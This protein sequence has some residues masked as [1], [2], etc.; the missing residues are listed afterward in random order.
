MHKTIVLLSVHGLDTLFASVRNCSWSIVPYVCCIITLGCFVWPPSSLLQHLLSWLVLISDTLLNMSI[1]RLSW[2]YW[3]IC[4][5]TS[6]HVIVDDLSSHVSSVVVCLPLSVSIHSWTSVWFMQQSTCQVLLFHKSHWFSQFSPTRNG[7]HFVVCHDYILSVEHPCCLCPSIKLRRGEIRI[8]DR[9]VR[10]GVCCWQHYCW[11]ERN[12][13]LLF[14]VPR[15][16]A[17]NC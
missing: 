2:I 8:I 7:S 1:F 16:W 15:L 10:R 3:S 14:F 4:S 9:P 12:V 5:L 6:A 13:P 17:L 11:G